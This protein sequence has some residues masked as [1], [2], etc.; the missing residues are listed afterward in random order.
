M[1]KFVLCF[2]LMIGAVPTFAAPPTEASIE[3]L[4]EVSR[5]RS[6][7]D[8]LK[9]PIERNI[10]ASA[11]IETI[12]KQ[13]TAEQQQKIEEALDRA[14]VILRSEL[15]YE[16]FRPLLLKLYAESLEQTEVDGM[17]AFYQTHAGQAVLSK[18]PLINAKSFTEVMREMLMTI[19][20][21]VNAEVREATQS[22]GGPQ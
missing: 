20:P 1:S 14:G 16:K 6:T 9:G 15:T 3:K 10:R 12:G 2:A 7:L 4:L 5:V 21:R 17:I 18:M 19:L 13:L 22:S 8:S 11:G